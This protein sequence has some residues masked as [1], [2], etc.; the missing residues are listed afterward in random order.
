[1]RIRIVVG[2]DIQPQ[3]KTIFWVW[4]LGDTQTQTQPQNQNQ[5]QF[6]TNERI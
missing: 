3:K 4:V 5:N 1:M 2:T 6:V